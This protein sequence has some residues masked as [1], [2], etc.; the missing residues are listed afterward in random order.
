M[1]DTGLAAHSAEHSWRWRNNVRSVVV[2]WQKRDPIAIGQ[3][4]PRK[5]QKN[6][7]F[8]RCEQTDVELEQVWKKHLQ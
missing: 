1:R 6:I 3:L 5:K 4:R 8:Q 2:S 7:N